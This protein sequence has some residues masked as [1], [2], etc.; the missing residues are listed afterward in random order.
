MRLHGAAVGHLDRARSSIGPQSDFRNSISRT[1]LTG[2]GQG[3]GGW[4]YPQ[5]EVIYATSCQLILSRSLYSDSSQSYTR[6]IALLRAD[7]AGSVV[8]LETLPICLDRPRPR[9][10][11]DSTGDT[12]LQISW[13]K[14]ILW[15]QDSCRR[16][17]A[18]GYFFWTHMPRPGEAPRQKRQKGVRHTSY[19]RQ[20][21]SRISTLRH[22][23]WETVPGVSYLGC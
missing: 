19:A 4:S 5:R 7:I 22:E 20:W 2:G 14:F 18:A 10:L 11:P 17:F 1:A 8:L 13:A 3:G 23:T 6:A 21:H 15:E 9:R 16:V 12:R